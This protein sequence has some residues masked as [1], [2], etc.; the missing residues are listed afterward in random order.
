MFMKLTLIDPIQ[1]SVLQDAVKIYQCL[2]QDKIKELFT[3]YTKDEE[4]LKFAERVEKYYKKFEVEN[5]CKES[6]E[7]FLK[8]RV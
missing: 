8:L 2:L 4:A 5:R 6:I 1:L 7:N 3:Y